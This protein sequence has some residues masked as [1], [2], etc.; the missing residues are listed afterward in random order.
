VSA[1]RTQVAFGDLDEAEQYKLLSV[2]VQPRPIA[3]V[4]TLAADG[5]PNLAP[6]SFFT[7]ASRNPP[8]VLV[9]IGE[10]DGVSGAEKDTLANV[11]ATG[12][13]VVNVPGQENA[14][15][16]AASSTQV[17]PDVDEHRLAGVTP[18]PSTSV[19][20]P[21]VAEALLALEC[22]VAGEVRVGT[23]VLVLAEVL[24]LT[25]RPGLLDERR[26]VSEDAES[27]LGR[28][29]GPFFAGPLTRVPQRS[30]IGTSTQGVAR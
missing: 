28:L 16:V 20:P 24:T 27:F 8:T 22:R 30:G 15:A 7:V 26:H 18:V 23:D 29:A 19:A 2:A 13:L 5:T 10:R 6:F 17:A 4:S 21:T 14:D 1:P 3:W 9:S 25:C 11:R 12:E